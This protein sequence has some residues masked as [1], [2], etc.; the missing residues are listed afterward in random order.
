[1]VVPR[2]V[3]RLDF[4]FGIVIVR[5]RMGDRVVDLAGDLACHVADHLPTLG[6]V[7]PLLDLCAQFRLVTATPLRV[8]RHSI[9]V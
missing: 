5:G 2:L 6:A 1:M 3:M 9:M 7:L 8:L 4:V